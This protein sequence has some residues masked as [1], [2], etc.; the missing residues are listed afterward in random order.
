VSGPIDGIIAW[1]W[2]TDSPNQFRTPFNND[3]RFA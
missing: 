3:D 1:S 2:A